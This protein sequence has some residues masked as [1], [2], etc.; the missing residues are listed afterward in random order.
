[1]NPR[2]W[3]GSVAGTGHEWL[4]EEWG[5]AGA[6]VCRERREGCSGQLEAKHKAVLF[7][8]LARTR[9]RANESTYVDVEPQVVFLTYVR[10]LLYWIESSINS[11]AGSRVDIEGNVS[12][13]GERDSP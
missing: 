5:I 4:A 7:L 9:L 10:N 8:S 6:E 13:R 2:G 12:L 3:P 11:C 1:M